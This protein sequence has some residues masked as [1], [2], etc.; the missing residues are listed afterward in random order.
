MKTKT[1][2]KQTDIG[3]IPEDWEID[4]LENHLIIKGRIGWKGLQISE[5][6]NTGPFIVGGL[7]IK[8]NGVVWEECAH[9]TEDRYEESPE[10]ML[11]EFDILMTKDG[12]IGKLAY[13]KKLPDK[14]TV[15]SH[16]HVI[17]KKSDEVLPQFLFYFFK[18]PRFQNL[19]E[20]KI[21]GSVVP[22]L[23]QKDINNTFFPI[24]PTKEQQ[25]IAKIL[26][27]LDSK[28]E[29]N[30][31]MN[32]TLEEIGKAIFKHWFVDFEFPNEEG[33]P[34]RSSNGDMIYNEELGKELPKGWKITSLD[35]AAEFTRGFSYKGSEKSKTD[36]EYVFVTLNSVKEFGGF[37]R[38]FSYVTSDRVR[39]KHFVRLGDVVISNTEQTKTGTL[40]GY[41]ALVE[42]P[43]QYEKDKGI[44]SHHITKVS[45]KISNLR[46]YLYRY[47]FTYQ[48]NAVKYHT[49]SVIWAL[50]VNNWAKNEKI[51]LPN[52][53]T[54]EEFE[55]FMESIFLKSLQNN[56][57]IETLSRIRDSLLPRL[58]SG[59]IRV[60]VE[61]R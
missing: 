56:L 50:D 23:T 55:S 30:Q 46:H 42:F 19:V 44:F 17:R 18:S 24:P 21:S 20:S 40:L 29:L 27:D 5:Y 35:Q 36:G 15:A 49:G 12:T 2:F 45:P 14:A 13:I 16:I 60:P 32:K 37:K 31:Q 57:Q 4:K 54:L 26:S 48:Q 58:M 25:A 61:A 38:E 43:F 59:K 3:M 8:D 11:R 9:V 51:I 52:P 53:N 22:A 33:K 34:Y 28:I 6:T 39:E 47:L 10:I 7:Q 41:P 1:K